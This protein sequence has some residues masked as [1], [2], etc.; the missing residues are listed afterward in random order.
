M[1]NIKIIVGIAIIIFMVINVHSV[2][3]GFLDD[4]LS[5]GT[6]WKPNSTTGNSANGI[7]NMQTTITNFLKNDIISTIKTVGNLIFFIVAGFLG[8]KYIWS[9]VEGKSQVKETLPTFGVALVF[10]YLAQAVYDFTSGSVTGA[11]GNNFS[12]VE[13]NIW[14]TVSLVLQIL[15][16]TGVFV[17][18]LK[19][20]F[21]SAD[22]KADIKKQMIP[23]VV[24]LIL[25]YGMASFMRF[26]VDTADQI[27]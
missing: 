27:I 23:L 5:G 26:I 24:G 1:K 7:N 13:G 25:V 4:I 20:M 19:Y 3:A 15:S 11:L 8:V 6:T 12:V 10:F 22:G 17:L 9:S 2:S 14:G 21:A 18:G 16:L